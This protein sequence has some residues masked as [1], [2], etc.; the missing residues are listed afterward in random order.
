VAATTD[1]C[2]DVA[3][4][5]PSVFVAVT[6]TRSVCPTSFDETVYCLLLAPPMFAQLPPARSQLCH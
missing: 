3:E 1:V 4:P 2:L 6:A 5:E